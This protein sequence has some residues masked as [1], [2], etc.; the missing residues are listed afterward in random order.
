MGNGHPGSNEQVSSANLKLTHWET[1]TK[2]PALAVALSTLIGLIMFATLA[3]LY[4]DFYENFGLMPA[5]LGFGYSETLYRSWGF[6]AVCFA[7]IAFVLLYAWLISHLF[8]R[9]KSSSSNRLF[10]QLGRRVFVIGLA[11]AAFLS[12]ALPVAL[13]VD[14]ISSIDSSMKRYS[15]RPF[16]YGIYPVTL[17]HMPLLSTSARAVERIS[18]VGKGVIVPKEIKGKRFLQLGTR[19]GCHILFDVNDRKIIK[20]PVG[21]FAVTEVSRPSLDTTR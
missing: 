15:G 10:S 8:R 16:K 19:E 11:I 9:S 3:L 21:G 14:H 2:I 20:L 17:F 7:F 4:E 1:L 12:Y 18:P 5:D 6:V 13:C